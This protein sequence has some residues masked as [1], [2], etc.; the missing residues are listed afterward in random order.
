MEQ[1]QRRNQFILPIAI[2]L[3]AIIFGAFYYAS[4]MRDRQ[5]SQ[6]QEAS[7]SWLDTMPAGTADHYGAEILQTGGVG[8][9]MTQ[10]TAYLL[11][12]Q[13]YLKSPEDWVSASFNTPADIMDVTC[14]EGYAMTACVVNGKKTEIDPIFGCRAAPLENKMQNKVTV[15]CSKK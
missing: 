10:E 6:K 5:S 8:S 12:E 2:L 7:N 9:R 11:T 1:Q 4:H 15:E 3:A 14:R 13:G